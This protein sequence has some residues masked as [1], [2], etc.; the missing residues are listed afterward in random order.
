MSAQRSQP[1]SPAPVGDG[2]ERSGAGPAQAPWCCQGDVPMGSDPVVC[3]GDAVVDGAVRVGA[4]IRA[5]GSVCVGASTEH[6]TIEAGGDIEVASA[7]VG[8][9][10]GSY[11]SGGSVRFRLA[12]GATIHAEDNVSGELEMAGCRIT[13]GGAVRCPIGHI[14][15]GH[16]TAVGGLVCGTLGSPGVGGV[17]TVVEVGIDDKLRRLSDRHAPTI[18][19]NLERAEKI[20]NKVGP[21]MAHMKRLTAQQ[22]ETATELLTEASMLYDETNAL[23]TTLRGAM[24]ESEMRAVR[25]VFVAAVIHPG[26]TIRFPAAQMIIEKAYKGP[27]RLVSD[28]RGSAAKVQAVDP[29]TGSVTTPKFALYADASLEALARAIAAVESAQAAAQAMRKAA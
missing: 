20:R 16:V 25:S 28:G 22:R 10:G 18:M 29:T 23:V 13:C 17:P 8:G 24:A 4:S 21:L 19:A 27:V 1:E 3:E 5:G 9:R 15:G 26:T 2:P 14:L 11:T 6:A 12:N 7:M